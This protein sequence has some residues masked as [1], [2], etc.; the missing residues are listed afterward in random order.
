VS[1]EG[2]TIKPQN[3]V[4]VSRGPISILARVDQ[5]NLSAHTSK[6]TQGSEPSR[7][8][9]NNNG[10]KVS[11]WGFST[12]QGSSSRHRSECCQ[13]HSHE[14]THYKNEANCVSS[15]NM[16]SSK[17]RRRRRAQRA[18]STCRT[19][20]PELL[21]LVCLRQGCSCLILTLP[22]VRLEI[23]AQRETRVSKIDAP[24]ARPIPRS[25]RGRLRK[26]P[27]R[28]RYVPGLAPLY[29]CPETVSHVSLPRDA[30]PPHG[31]ECG[32]MPSRQMCSSHGALNSYY[33]TAVVIS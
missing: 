10:I 21:S 19:Y 20:T 12:R 32:A 29:L 30:A 3:V 28:T 1:D 9:A 25:R 8:A 18:L 33:A 6:T 17:I 5:E 7:A 2:I 14:G 31:G 24:T 11:G 27:I 4:H 15:E 23:I 26:V 22:S 13:H 16:H